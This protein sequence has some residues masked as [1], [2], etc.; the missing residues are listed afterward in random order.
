MKYPV[1]ILSC[2]IA[3]GTL[4]GNAQVAAETAVEV[5]DVLASYP[6]GEAAFDAFIKA[7][8]K[9]TSTAA[10]NKKKGEVIIKFDIDENGLPGNYQVVKS[11]GYGCDEQAI[12]VLR[13]MPRWQPGIIKGRKIKTT[14]QKS[15]VFNVLLPVAEIDA[16]KE[17][18]LLPD[19]PASYGEK[20][21]DLATWLQEN[22]HYPRGMKKSIPGVVM[23]RFRITTE[24]VTENI[25]IISGLNDAIDN[26]IIRVIKAMNNWKP[27][28]EKYRP[29]E[30]Y[31]ELV[32]GFKNKK[33]LLF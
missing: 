14:L 24:G 19:Q 20:E 25:N 5:K 32:I 21:E 31:K 9:I 17:K 27:R 13:S 10:D 16:E 26:E 11:M 1:F 29:V 30:S 22:F 3:F 33:P 18:S 6:G 23:V 7:H 28:Q 8:L 4:T 2:C 15:F 12:L